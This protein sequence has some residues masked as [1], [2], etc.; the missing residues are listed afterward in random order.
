M[1]SL[2][3]APF[4]PTQPARTKA[5]L[6]PGANPICASEPIDRFFAMPT[7]NASSRPEGIILI[8]FTFCPTQRKAAGGDQK[9]AVPA[10][11]CFLGE[12]GIATQILKDLI[13]IGRQ[14]QVAAGGLPFEG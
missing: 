6:P 14:L 13:L 12:Q 11:T 1:H 10:N 7:T 4:T 8:N 5:L 2:T 9:P 3:T